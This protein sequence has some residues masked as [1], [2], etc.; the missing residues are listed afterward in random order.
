MFYRVADQLKAQ[1][2]DVHKINFNSGDVAY[3]YPRK[4]SLFRDSLDNLP[5]FMEDIW[6]KYG[7]TDQVMFGNCR[8]VHRPAVENGERF[9]IR[10]F[11]F[12]CGY[13]RPY[14]IT[15]EREGVNGHSL[16][17][18]NPDWYRTVAKRLPA[19]QPPQ[20]FKSSFAPQAIHDVLY[21]LCGIGDPFV[22]PHYRYHSPYSILTEYAGYA[23]R[24][25]LVKLQKNNE[26]NKLN[27]LI[28]QAT[29]YYLFPLQLNS[30][31]QIVHYSK[32]ASMM[33]AIRDVVSSFAK[34]APSHTS[35]VIKNHPLDIGMIDYRT[36]I[37]QLEQEFN[38]EGRT[39]YLETGNIRTLLEHALGT[40]TVNST[41][42]GVSLQLNRPTITLAECIFSID[43]L[44]SQKPLDEFWTTLP[45]PDPE[46]FTD[47]YK[48][49]IH[50]TQVNGGLY[51]NEGTRL[52][53]QNAVRILG[54]DK[55]ALERCHDLL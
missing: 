31:A 28:S 23:K 29:P 38:I 18:R 14:W 17:P 36:L 15:L 30:D 32:Y 2:H 47:F 5:T 35:L 51:S 34:H 12:E 45:K 4:A 27:Q 55:S 41:T 24:T 46:L 16:L 20:D 6:S 1:G 9:G 40:V 8:P 21:H 3:W 22:A 19:L 48:T 43:G 33:D 44:T 49:V 25:T 50:A 37:S 42:A 26:A 53:A 13:F 10:T 7:I 11:V 39:V 52:A 54:S